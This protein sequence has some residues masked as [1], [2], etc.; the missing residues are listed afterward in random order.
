M[1]LWKRTT[2]WFIVVV[3]LLICSL[4]DII[5]YSCSIPLA[6]DTADGKAEMMDCPYQWVRAQ[7][8]M[9][10]TAIVYH[11]LFTLQC[12]TMC[13]ILSMTSISIF[14]RINLWLKFVLRT[15]SLIIFT[16]TLTN[17]CSIYQI[18]FERREPADRWLG[19]IGFDPIFSHFYYVFMVYLILCLIDRQIEYIFRLDFKLSKRLKDEKQEAKIM[20]EINVILLNNILPTYVVQKY[21]DD[22]ASF[23]DQIY[24]ESYEFVAVMFA[25]IPNYSEFYCENKMNDNGIKCLQL[26]NEIICDFDQIL[27]QS[28]FHRIEKIKTIGSTYM[29]AAGLRPGRGSDE[30]GD[31]VFLFT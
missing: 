19:D 18:F 13:V 9:I 11:C 7:F 21:L 22:T 23:T 26:L 17:R 20:A 16:A 8:S 1:S 3:S 28:R 2:I 30:V 4:H 24:S 31:Q 10:T 14:I 5:V 27:S 12:Y 15:I 25:S 6:E 29:T